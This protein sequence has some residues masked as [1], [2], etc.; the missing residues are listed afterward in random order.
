MGESI[1]RAYAK[2]RSQR[3]WELSDDWLYEFYGDT[4]NWFPTSPDHER[5]VLTERLLRELRSD[6]FA[7]FVLTA[8]GASDEIPEGIELDDAD[9]E[10]LL[11]NDVWHN[12]GSPVTGDAVNIMVVG[13]DKQKAWRQSRIPPGEPHDNPLPPFH[14]DELDARARAGDGG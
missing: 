4:L 11:A 8:P 12:Y 2:W 3:L 6:G 14:P 9:F 1:E 10:A 7:R 5:A 13:T